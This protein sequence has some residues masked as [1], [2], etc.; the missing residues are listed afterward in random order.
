M[1]QLTKENFREI[2]KLL[3]ARL[4]DN[5]T[6]SR[7][8]FA[9]WDALVEDFGEYLHASNGRFDKARFNEACFTGKFVGAGPKKY[10]DPTRVR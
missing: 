5:I 8:E 6:G 9:M 2:S 10:D 3:H 7:A 4:P 1:T